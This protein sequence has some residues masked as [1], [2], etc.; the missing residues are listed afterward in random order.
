MNCGG[1][2]RITVTALIKKFKWPRCPNCAANA[3]LIYE[4]EN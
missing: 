2:F 4:T 1:A 3:A